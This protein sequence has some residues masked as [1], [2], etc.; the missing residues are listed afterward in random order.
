M[1]VEWLIL[2]DAA[3]VVGNKLYLL[4]GGWDRLIVRKGFPVQQQIGLA[5]SVSVPWNN[6]NERHS[7]E[8][9]IATE[10][11]MR[12]GT[13]D[14]SFEV[15]RPVGVSPGQGQRIQVAANA[16]LK[17]DAA[18]MYVIIARVNGEESRRVNFTVVAD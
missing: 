8:I 9:E 6:T 15:G 1:E 2:C 4:G 10:D 11:G 7:F 12:V 16:T 13:A 3:Q 14:G 18:G 5:I 17:L